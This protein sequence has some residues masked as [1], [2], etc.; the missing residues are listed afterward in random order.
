MS[1]FSSYH[2]VFKRLVLQTHK[3]QGFF[4]KGLKC[5]LQ[6]VSI[7][8]S[9]EFCRLVGVEA[10]Q[11]LNILTKEN[12]YYENVV[13][14][15]LGLGNVFVYQCVFRQGRKTLS[16]IKDVRIKTLHYQKIYGL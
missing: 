11:C 1:N 5:H 10:V 12:Q 8:T 4:G 3:N 2:I 13:E 16:L 7:W 14:K 15:V 6:F 9:L